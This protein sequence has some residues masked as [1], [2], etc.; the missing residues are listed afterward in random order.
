MIREGSIQIPFTFAAGRAGS[1]FLTALRDGQTILGAQCTGCGKVVCPPR[2]V[3]P[4]CFETS[5]EAV[6]LG[7]E[8]TLVSITEIPAQGAFGL[9]KLDGADTAMLHRLCGNANQFVV[10]DR[11]KARF[12]VHRTANILD[13]QGFT[14]AIEPA[15]KV[16]GALEEGGRP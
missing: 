9:V 11:V 4:Y 7:T 5:L 16:K 13:I 6:D 8:G 2:P 1:Q 12:A 14:P 10:G 15:N 3:C